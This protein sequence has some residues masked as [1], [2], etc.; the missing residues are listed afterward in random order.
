ML[1]S[2]CLT[3]GNC[4]KY[5]SLA[6]CFCSSLLLHFSFVSRLIF[7]YYF[8][9]HIWIIGMIFVFL[10]LV[11]NLTAPCVCS[12]KIWIMINLLPS[13]WAIGNRPQC[14]LEDNLHS[15]RAYEWEK[16]G[17]GLTKCLPCALCPEIPL[18]VTP[19][20]APWGYTSLNRTRNLASPGCHSFHY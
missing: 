9:C 6:Y 17:S 16:K 13:F 1:L 12:D 20:R 8:C 5:T 3:W 10:F 19:S 2:N 11:I 15:V 18:G 4:K 14:C 7:I